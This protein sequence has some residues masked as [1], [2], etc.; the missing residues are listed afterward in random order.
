MLHSCNPTPNETISSYTV[1][2]LRNFP[3]NNNNYYYH[4]HHHYSNEVYYDNNNYNQ[5]HHYSSK[6]F[7]SPA[8]R[9]L[10]TAFI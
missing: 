5:H 7:L 10:T 4:L 8:F 9:L 6:V 1:L 2:N 3:N